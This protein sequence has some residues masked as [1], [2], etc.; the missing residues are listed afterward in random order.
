VSPDPSLF[1]LTRLKEDV[2]AAHGEITRREVWN[3]EL[4]KRRLADEM[5]RVA[6]ID[7][8]E[9]G[10]AGDPARALAEVT[11]KRRI[12]ELCESAIEAGET[13]PSTARMAE[14]V[15]RIMTQAYVGHPDYDVE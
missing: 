8:D 9:T 1:L 13:D 12:I 14:Q 2:V 11:A 3:R 10:V 4:D 6:L 15:L 5:L 7:H